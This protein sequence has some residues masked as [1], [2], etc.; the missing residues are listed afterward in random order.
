MSKDG[1]EGGDISL[2]MGFLMVVWLVVATV[3]FILIYL[4]KGI[5]NLFSFIF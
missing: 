4:K 3:I 1:G 2:T 5:V